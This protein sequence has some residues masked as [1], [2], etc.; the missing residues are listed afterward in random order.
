MSRL[1][2]YR[3]TSPLLWISSWRCPSLYIHVYRSNTHH[4]Y[5]L[6]MIRSLRLI[7]MNDKTGLVHP[8]FVRLSEVSPSSRICHCRARTLCI[9]PLI[10]S[11]ELPR[12]DGSPFE[13]EHK[14]R[15]HWLSLFLSFVLQKVEVIL[16]LTVSR[17]VCLGVRHP[18]GTSDQSFFFF[19]FFNYF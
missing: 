5:E 14:K 10:Q 6:R 15:Q 7:N 12:S 13:R 16:R 18:S 8:S 4:P 2:K 1:R 3:V 11:P 19:F 9:L 17:P